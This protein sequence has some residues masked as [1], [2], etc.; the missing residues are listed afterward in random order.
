MNLSPLWVAFL[1][2]RGVEAVHWS[3]VGSASAPDAT[4]AEYAEANGFI[5]FTHD[6]DFGAL[7]AAR[8]VRGP[9]V[10]QLRTQEVLPA[11]IGE[12]LLACLEAS[13]S[14]LEIGAL[15]TIDP[16]RNRIRILPI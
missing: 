12:V 11:F 6:L 4:I 3:E 16:A 2:A 7:L 10:V 13:R 5:I 8:K 14:H 1:R 15:L 9:S